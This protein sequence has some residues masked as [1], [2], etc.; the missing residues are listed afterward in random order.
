MKTI[1]RRSFIKTLGKAGIG[2]LLAV[3]GTRESTALT[4]V[5]QF[6]EEKRVPTRP[7]GKT[8]IQVA[9][10]G[11]GCSQDL[12]SKHLLLKQAIKM[13]V[14]YWDT[15]H[16][17][18]NSEEAI[19]NYFKKYPKDRKKVFLVT[20]SRSSDPA[21]MTRSLETSLQR[22]RCDYV[23]M[24]F[25]HSVSDV[26]EE[27]TKATKVWA[28]KEKKKGRIRLFG[29]STHKN[30]EQCLSAAAKLGWVDGIMT[31]Y[32]Y[33]LMNSDSMK[34]ACD[35]CAK[36]GIGLVAMKT[37]APFFAKVFADIGKEDITAQSLTA[38]FIK[39]GFTVEQA[40]LKAVW[41]NQQITSI[42]SEMTNMTLLKANVAASMGKPKLSGLEKTLFD[43]HASQTASYY[44]TGCAEYCEP[45]MACDVPISDVMRCL[46]YAHEYE[47]TER[48]MNILRQ[49]SPDILNRLAV[50]DF[51]PAEMACPKKMPIS[52]L[53]NEVVKILA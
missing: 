27:L 13:G 1:D 15:A 2:S 36:E 53:I 28:E 14:T 43:L 39:K 23:D 25:V 20:K 40:K 38:Q 24:F 6:A 9:M 11:F 42:C 34:K 22:M 48:A 26:K 31:S 50:A 41:E 46:M 12:N 47:E 5:N 29:F 45:E 44:C 33:R 49:M 52:I 17:Y 16:T 3:T 7:F 18:N 37:Q 8:G 4:S 10:L 35:A 21:R 32:N 19:G 51:T 30:M